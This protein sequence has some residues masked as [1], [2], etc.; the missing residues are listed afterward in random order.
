M[1]CLRV[2]EKMNRS[3]WFERD[4]GKGNMGEL[5]GV[6]RRAF[7]TFLPRASLLI[8]LF[9]PRPQPSW[10]V[11]SVRAP[12]VGSTL[13]KLPSARYPFYPSDLISDSLTPLRSGFNNNIASLKKSFRGA[14]M[15]VRG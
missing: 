2:R 6:V 15:L 13:I 12:S 1:S 9:N 4:T 7:S 14:G 8:T 11:P 3:P 5:V 10:D